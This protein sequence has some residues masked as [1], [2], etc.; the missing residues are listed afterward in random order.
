MDSFLLIIWWNHID[1]YFDTKD[2]CNVICICKPQN[3]SYFYFTL[4]LSSI[5][6]LDFKTRLH[7]ILLAHLYI[8]SLNSYYFV[9]FILFFLSFYFIL[10]FSLSLFSLILLPI[11]TF[12]LLSP[13]SYT[14]DE[15]IGNHEYIGTSILRIYRI[16]GYFGK[17]YR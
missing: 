10:F 6:F 5:L 11:P 1:L 15:N 2:Y 12:S 17:K 9:Y 8:L 7:F 16:G 13:I 3:L 4:I 14:K